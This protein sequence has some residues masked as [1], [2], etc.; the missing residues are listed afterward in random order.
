MI[1]YAMGASHASEKGVELRIFSSQ[2]KSE[3]F[4]WV[5]EHQLRENVATVTHF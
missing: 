1:G 5:L 2:F 3:Q 4:I